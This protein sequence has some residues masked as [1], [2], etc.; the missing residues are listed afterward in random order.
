MIG[1]GLNDTGAMAQ[2]D[3]SIAVDSSSTSAMKRADVC[4]L[5]P[6]I[7]LVELAMKYAGAV[8]ARIRLSFCV[9]TIYN[10]F[11]LYLAARGMVSPVVAAILMPISSL[12][13]TYLSTSWIVRKSPV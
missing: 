7:S 3:I 4:L 9:A 10:L 13:I 11:G 8:R 6:D 12:T 2:A 1:N 5:R